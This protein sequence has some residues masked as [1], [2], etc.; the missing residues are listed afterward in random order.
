[1]T[2]VHVRFLHCVAALSVAVSGFV[3]GGVTRAE[4]GP[5]PLAEGVS[6]LGQRAVEFIDEHGYRNVGVLK[7]RVQK[8]GQDVSD[9]VGTLNTDLATQLET[10]VA[11]YRRNK[12]TFGVI[13]DAS[14]TA[15]GIN[16]ASHLSTDGRSRLFSGS[17]RLAWGT[18][19]AT[20]AADAFLVGVAAVAA[21][22]QSMEIAIGAIDTKSDEMHKVASVRCSVSP[23]QLV[24]MGESFRTRAV[25]SPDVVAV[26]PNPDSSAKSKPTVPKDFMYQSSTSAANSATKILSQQEPFPLDAG[27]AP[28]NVSV[29][30][31]G[32][33]V[34][35]EVRGGR[36]FLREP[37]EGQ[38][39]AIRVEKKRRDGQRIGVVVKVNGENTT[40]RQ[41]DPDLY[42]WKWILS[43]ATPAVTVRGYHIDQEQVQ[44]FKV[45]SSADSSKREI[46]YG[47]DVGTITFTVFADEN[48]TP[49]ASAGD[50]PAPTPAQLTDAIKLAPDLALLTRQVMVAD[51]GA[52]TPD[53][54]RQNLLNSVG[55]PSLDRGLMVPAS[56]AEK[57]KLAVTDF[58]SRSM[59]EMSAVITY[60]TPTTTPASK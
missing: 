56:A 17:Y 35:I 10:A 1:M 46:D 11:I 37:R 49:V 6:S 22:L 41:T 39:V 29:T 3:F 14:G 59:P 23:A 5:L 38:K 18:P 55:G 25:M 26:T 52:A 43:D 30:Y 20:V 53:L 42:C 44:P 48:P 31:D 51:I 28:I 19:P 16:G 27:D 9:R 4:D 2:S 60:Y 54:L 15:A 24:G 50:R 33:V 40:K 58:K 45:L 34:P 32:T 21:D 57:S 12:M 8:A 7:F 13:A 36:A 47:K